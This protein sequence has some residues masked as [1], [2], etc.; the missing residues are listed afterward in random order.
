MEH[1]APL[2][3]VLA[4]ETDGATDP[5]AYG[6]ALRT[7]AG[8]VRADDERFSAALSRWVLGGVGLSVEASPPDSWREALWDAAADLLADREGLARLMEKAAAGVEGRRG[9]VRVNLQAMLRTKVGWR[10][11][12]KQRRDRGWTSRRAEA[13][14]KDGATVDPEARCLA[15]LVIAQAAREFDEPGERQALEGL[16]A[17]ESISDIAR[18]T[19]LT[20]QAIYRLLGRL[21]TW[22]DGADAERT[23]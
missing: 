6:A 12:D 2:R 22:I 19:P 23:P 14:T 10:A 17:G 18:R 4:L 16:L 21:R 9:P 13:K 3:R 5:T 15:G 7:L 20:R 11:R 1:D 8:A